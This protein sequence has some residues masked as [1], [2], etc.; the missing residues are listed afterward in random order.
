MSLT[1]T[2]PATRAGPGA[3]SLPQPVIEDKGTNASA[4]TGPDTMSV[5]PAPRPSRAVGPAMAPSEHR[6]PGHTASSPLHTGSPAQKPQIHSHTGFQAKGRRERMLQAMQ[7]SLP[8]PTENGN[9]AASVPRAEKGHAQCNP[10]SPPSCT[11]RLQRPGRNI[12]IR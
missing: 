8:Q 2:F 12:Q 7:T 3:A 5:S 4:G 11:L 6:L 10:P 9:A 1:G